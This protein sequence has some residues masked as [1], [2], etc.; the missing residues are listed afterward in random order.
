MRARLFLIACTALLIAGCSTTIVA[1]QAMDPSLRASFRYETIEVSSRLPELPVDV[2]QRLKDAVAGR[3]S[4]IP[5]GAT[6]ARI[7][8]SV[9][10]YRVVTG[11]ERFLIGM[12]A[13]S[14]KM[15]VAVKVSDAA[16]QQ[17]A[18]FEVERSANPGGYGAFYDQKEATIEA[19]ADGIAEALGAA[20]K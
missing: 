6:P 5:Q 16:G 20:K 10:T 3:V 13:G 11:G 7:D 8:I 12:L 15:K 1:R 18:D 14:N 17:L 2:A 19:V 4:K 9:V